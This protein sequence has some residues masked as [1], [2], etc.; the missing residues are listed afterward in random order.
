MDFHFE[1]NSTVQGGLDDGCWVRKGMEG[2]FQI[3]K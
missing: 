2:M 1:T 3:E